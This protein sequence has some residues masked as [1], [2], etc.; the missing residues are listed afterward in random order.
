MFLFPSFFLSFRCLFLGNKV[1]D[2]QNILV[3]WSYQSHFSG[4]IQNMWTY[5]KRRF[6]SLHLSI[7][8]ES[9][10]HGGRW[11]FTWWCLDAVVTWPALSPLW[12]AFKQFKPLFAAFYR[13][14]PL[15]VQFFH[16]RLTRD[17]N[18]AALT[19]LQLT[20]V[21]TASRIQWTQWS[22]TTNKEMII[23]VLQSGY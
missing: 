7:I 14:A 11:F 20:G 12:G 19:R 3:T 2:T 22:D 23:I 21:C 16:F 5:T 13:P 10:L 8:S 18:C 6:V 9:F 15:F 1:K 4:F 17:H